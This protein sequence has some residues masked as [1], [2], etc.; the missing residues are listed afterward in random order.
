MSKGKVFLV[1]AGPGDPDLLTR[2]AFGLMHHCDVVCYDKLV[3]PAILS[4]IP[5]HVQLFEV[6]Y[7][8]YRHCHIDYGMHPDV[9][10]FALEGKQVLRLKAGDPCIFGRITEECRTLKEHGIDYEI[11][12]GITAALGAAAYSGFP[13][14]SAGIAS[15]VTFA[16][17]HQGSASLS[18][19]A[20]LGQSSG[21]LVLYMGAKKLAQHAERLIEQGRCPTTPVAHISSA[22]CASHIV[23]KGSLATIGEQVLALDNHEPALVVMGDVVT[24]AD[25]LEWR[26]LLPLSGGR[27]LLCG[28]YSNA[29]LLK[30]SGAEIFNAPSPQLDSFVD[31]SLLSELCQFSALL[32]ADAAAVKLWWQGLIDNQWDVR[33]FSMPISAENTE[34]AQALKQVGIVADVTPE[35]G[36]YNCAVLSVPAGAERQSACHGVYRY[37]GSRRYP[38][39]RFQ[40]PAIDWLLVDDIAQAKSLLLQHSGLQQATIVALNEEAQ[41]WADTLPNGQLTLATLEAKLRGKHEVMDVV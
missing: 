13:L 15:D 12:P 20:A 25:E 36:L 16:S 23:T 21:T 10:Q 37:L 17:G 4:C 30:S 11:V 40:L 26:H 22:T 27:V 38:L 32:F 5:D 24:Q 31:L 34:A 8:G 18:S 14:T 29:D 3:S 28:H 7:R 19:W 9:I 6:G 1:G 35:A 33:R 39:F 41:N 2:R